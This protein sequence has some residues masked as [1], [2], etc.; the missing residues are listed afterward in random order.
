MRWLL[1]SLAL[2]MQGAGLLLLWRGGWFT[3]RVKAGRLKKLS[4]PAATAIRDSFIVFFTG[5]A[6]MLLFALW[7]RHFILAFGQAAASALCLLG[8][9]TPTSASPPG[10]PHKTGLS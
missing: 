9:R 8:G 5:G 2:A 1:F 10:A 3:G 6:L 4:M 7:E